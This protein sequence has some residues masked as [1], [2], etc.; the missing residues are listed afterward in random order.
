MSGGSGLEASA[1]TGHAQPMQTSSRRS[2]LCNLLEFNTHERSRQVWAQRKVRGAARSPSLASP[3]TALM[4]VLPG[5]PLSLLLHALPPLQAMYTAFTV[6][7]DAR[8]G[9][10]TGIS[11]ADRA[12]TVAELADPGARAEDFRKP[13][14][15]FPLRYRP[16]GVIVRPGHTEAAVDLARLAGCRPA[17][18]S[19]EL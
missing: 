9:I 12:T 15:I 3:A 4:K 7:V 1:T 19:K 6:T 14:H 13:G 16:G 10:T 11:A 18:G 17:G 8:H 5:C 2:P